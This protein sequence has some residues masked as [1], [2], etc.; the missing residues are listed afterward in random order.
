[1]VVVDENGGTVKIMLS[2]VGDGSY[3]GN[4]N[5]LK[6]PFVVG[7]DVEGVS[8]VKITKLFLVNSKGEYIA[9]E[10]PEGFNL[11]VQKAE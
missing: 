1:M 6:L 3:N 8:K 5:A 11:W 9:I 7:D 2:N 4:M 10:I